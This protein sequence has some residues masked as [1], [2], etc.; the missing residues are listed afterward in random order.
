MR[1]TKINQRGGANL[2]FLDK[3]VLIFEKYWLVFA[4][5]LFGI[6]MLK[7][8]IDDQKAKN[9]ANDEA[10]KVVVNNSQ[11]STG[12]P[13]TIKKKSDVVQKKYPYVTTKDMQRYNTVA[14]GIAIALGTN[15]QDNIVIAGVV[16]WFNVEGWTENEDEAVRLLKTVPTTFPIVEDLY[17]NV[18]TNSRNLKYDLKKYL[19]SSDLEEVRKVQKK[20]GKT[21]I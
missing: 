16:D 19:S 2:P 10:N 4:V 8:Y 17:Y 20:Y 9:L 11:N 5:L 6:P 1:V 7:R 3:S 14:Q 13:V 15:V 12:N 18:Y 21:F